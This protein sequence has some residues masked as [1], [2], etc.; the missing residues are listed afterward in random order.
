MVN[1]YAQQDGI[2]P[3]TYQPIQKNH[4]PA[5]Q[6]VVGLTAAGL[7]NAALGIAGSE[8]YHNHQKDKLEDQAA[9][10]SAKIAA[11]DMPEQNSEAQAAREAALIAAPETLNDIPSDDKIMS[12]G[13]GMGDLEVNGQTERV[14]NLAKAI[15]RPLTEDSQSILAAGQNHTSVQSI[16]QLHVPGEFPKQ[17]PA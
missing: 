3:Y 10:E 1:Q 4:I 9:L 7:G 2:N 8:A 5:K 14:S 6:A 17:A 13:R 15:L 16:S 12:G 11:P